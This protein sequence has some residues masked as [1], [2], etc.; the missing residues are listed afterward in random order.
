MPSNSKDLFKGKRAKGQKGKRAKKQKG[1]K[2]KE[3]FPPL[4]PQFLLFI[5]G[6]K[7]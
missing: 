6:P 5:A 7:F 4:R 2:A 3:N 1:K